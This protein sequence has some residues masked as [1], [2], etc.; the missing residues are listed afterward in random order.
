VRGGEN[1][2]IGTQTATHRGRLRVWTLQPFVG[3]A[4]NTLY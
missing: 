3:F 2:Q 4:G 1:H